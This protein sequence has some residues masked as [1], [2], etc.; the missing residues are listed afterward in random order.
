[1]HGIMENLGDATLFAGQM[2]ALLVTAATIITALTPS[3]SDNELLD[4]V[5]GYLNLIAG[6]V[7]HNRNADDREI[8]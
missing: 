1:M 3:K 4:R 7:G 6:N 2:L 5:L 8:Y